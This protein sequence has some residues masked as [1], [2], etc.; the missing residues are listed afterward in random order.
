MRRPLSLILASVLALAAALGGCAAAPLPL[1]P[2]EGRTLTPGRYLAGVWRDPE[3]QPERASFRL[4]A[5][6][7][8]EA[9][10][11]AADRFLPLLEEELRRA[12]AANGLRLTD[13]RE[14]CAVSGAIHR[15]EVQGTRFR[16]LRGRISA[17]L[18][19]SGAISQG[20][21][22]V[23]AFR[24]RFRL[25]SPISPGAPAPREEELLL[26]RI[27]QELAR[28]LLTELLLHGPPGE[29]M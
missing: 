14:A 1:V 11:T 21:R 8:E 18:E 15:V 28:R 2:V 7:V 25:Y 24:D 19:V 23:F 26:T 12:F 10:D 4:A 6:P 17:E 20:E 5:F 13:T 16:F 29:S 27:S 22:V 3:F 9:V